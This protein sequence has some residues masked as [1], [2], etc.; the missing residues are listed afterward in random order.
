[1]PMSC[2]DVPDDLLNPI[3]TWK[4]KTAYTAKAM[5]LSYA[6]KNNFKKF[7][8]RADM[9]LIAGGPKQ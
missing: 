1:M 4:N 6:F 8:D 3:N 9:E 2:P 5:D 7:E